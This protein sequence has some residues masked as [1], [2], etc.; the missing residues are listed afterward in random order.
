MS[1]CTFHVFFPKEDSILRTKKRVFVESDLLLGRLVMVWTM[2]QHQRAAEWEVG[3]FDLQSASLALHYVTPRVSPW[4]ALLKHWD[5]S[6]CNINKDL[7]VYSPFLSFLDFLLAHFNLQMIRLCFLLHGPGLREIS[8]VRRRCC[9][10]SGIFEVRKI[11]PLLSRP[12]LSPDL[13][14]NHFS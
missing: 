3:I 9:K 11:T 2:L 8:H 14:K 1:R 12:L 13:P 10:R 4:L 7:N 6:S 5:A